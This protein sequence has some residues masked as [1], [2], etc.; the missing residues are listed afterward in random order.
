MLTFGAVPLLPKRGVEFPIS[1]QSTSASLL[2]VDLDP[3][4]QGCVRSCHRSQR[5]APLD[6]PRVTRV[7]RHFFCIFFANP[8]PPRVTVT[9]TSQQFLRHSGSFG[10]AVPPGDPVLD[11]ENP[12]IQK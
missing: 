9:H 8:V 6:D 5:A 11:A 4:T 7:K 3:N 2:R 1:R 12:D 10:E